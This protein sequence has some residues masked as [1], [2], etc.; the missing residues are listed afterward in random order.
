MARLP[1]A[2]F[3]SLARSQH[4]CHTHERKRKK[5]N[6]ATRHESLP[7][8]PPVG[9]RARAEIATDDRSAGEISTLFSQQLPGQ[10]AVRVMPHLATARAVVAAGARPISPPVTVE[11]RHAA[12]Q[13]WAAP[14]LGS[15]VASACRVNERGFPGSF[16]FNKPFKNTGIPRLLLSL[17]LGGERDCTCCD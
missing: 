11:A 3:S 14:R 8:A 9:L 1:K 15:G 10:E 17:L 13:E 12:E 5:P 16:R 6:T 4:Q 2:D 7:T